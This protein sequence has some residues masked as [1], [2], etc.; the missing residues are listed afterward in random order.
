MRPRKK[1]TVRRRT[2]PNGRVYYVV[3]IGPAY[4]S[5]VEGKNGG[6]SKFYDR[7]VAQAVADEM[8]GS[9]VDDPLI[10]E[11]ET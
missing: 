6:E 11:R 9:G 2:W 5:T 8:N 10:E 4:G 7:S 3:G 1:W